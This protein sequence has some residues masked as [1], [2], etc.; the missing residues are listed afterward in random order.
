VAGQVRGLWRA[1]HP[2]YCGVDRSHRLI[3]ECLT[4][5]ILMICVQIWGW[6]AYYTII[7]VFV[8]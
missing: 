2:G 6:E 8:E 4:S 5:W 7:I 1:A 3:T